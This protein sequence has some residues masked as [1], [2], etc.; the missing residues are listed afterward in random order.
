MPHRLQQRCSKPAH[1]P[2]QLQRKCSAP[3]QPTDQRQRKC[4]TGR[5]S[6][7]QRCTC[8]REHHR[9]D[10]KPTANHNRR[11]S[12]PTFDRSLHSISFSCSAALRPFTVTDCCAASHKIQ[13][14]VSSSFVSGG[15]SFTSSMSKSSLT[16]T[17]AFCHW[18][19]G[20]PS[21]AVGAAGLDAVPAAAVSATGFAS[22]RGIGA[23]GGDASRRL[24]SRARLPVE[25][26]RL[27]AADSRPRLR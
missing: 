25:T 1:Q 26:D 24:S 12:L 22:F 16:V 18:A 2:N 19:A 20:I 10:Y 14:W 4:S 9:T 21:S 6:R 3:G 5:C 11:R 8:P 15:S 7:T 17:A 27:R 13:A 23:A